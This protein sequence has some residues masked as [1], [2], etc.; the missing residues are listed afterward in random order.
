MPRNHKLLAMYPVDLPAVDDTELTSASENY[1]A[2]LNATHSCN[3]WFRSLL[4]SKEIAVTPANI[5][6]LQLFEDEHPA[7]TVLALHPPHDQT[8]VLALYLHKKWWPLDDVLQTSSE[9]RSGLQPVQ[10]IMERLIVFLLSQVVEKPRPH[11]EVSFSLH[12]PTETCKVLW[13]DGQAVGFYTIKHKGSLCDSWSSRC[14][15]LPVLDTVLVRRRCRRR[16]FGLQILHDFCSSFSSEEFLG[17][18]FPLSSGMVAVIRKFLQQH[19]EHRARLYEVEAPGGWSQ[20]RNIWLNIQLGRYASE[21]TG[22]AVLTPVNPC[23][24]NAPP[25]TAS[26][27][28]CDV[29]QEDNSLSSELSGTGCCSSVCTDILDFK[30]PCRPQRLKESL[31][32]KEA[33]SRKP[34]IETPEQ[35]QNRSKRARRTSINE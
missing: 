28:L 35:M 34:R 3:E 23:N 1:L 24:S 19:E 15:L 22:S 12:P 32:W 16:G 31:K 9:S 26:A 14:Y 7:C 13:K 5:R 27:R 29:N 17:V 21:Q 33:S 2:S 30:A 18:S 8:Q 6:Q 20:R 25:I 11:G 10:S 4:T